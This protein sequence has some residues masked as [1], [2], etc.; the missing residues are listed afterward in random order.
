MSIRGA[1]TRTR[2]GSAAIGWVPSAGES[3]FVAYLLGLL[4]ALL[5]A[6]VLGIAML[7]SDAAPRAAAWLLIAALPVGLPATIG[8]ALATMA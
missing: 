8:Y 6:I 4:V 1:A 3:F 7:R 5:G 2:L